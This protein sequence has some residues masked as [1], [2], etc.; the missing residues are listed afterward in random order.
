[1][2]YHK[3][4]SQ[5]SKVA[6]WGSLGCF[7]FRMNGLNKKVRSGFRFFSVYSGFIRRLFGC[8]FIFFSIQRFS[9]GSHLLSGTDVPPPHVRQRMSLETRAIKEFP[10]SYKNT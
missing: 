5:R 3:E 9:K 7:G 2:F 8:G 6:Q 1:M 10:T 4:Y